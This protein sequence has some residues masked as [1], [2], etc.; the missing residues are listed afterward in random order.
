LRSFDMTGFPLKMTRCF[1]IASAIGTVLSACAVHPQP[2][3]DAERT[4]AANTDRSEL[5]GRD[6][7]VTGPITLEEAMARAIRHNLDQRAKMMEQVLAQK[8]LDL[9]NFDLLPKLTTAAGYT[10]RDQLLASRSVGLASGSTTVPPSYSSEKTDLTYD[11]GFSWNLLDLGVSYY[12]AREQADHVLVLEERRRKVVQLMMQQVR[13]AYWEAAGAQRLRERIEPL[14]EDAHRALA[15]SQQAQ[16]EQ[17]RTPVEALNYQRELLEIMRQLEVVRGHLEEAKPRLAALMNLDPGRDY[18]LAPPDGFAL[19]QFRMPMERMEQLALEGRP[20]LI[21]A[22]YN[23][24]IGVEEAHKALAKLLPGIELQV[25]TNYDNNSFLSYN[26]WQNAGVQVSWNL[27]NLLNVKNIRGAAAAQLTLAHTQRLALSMA[28]LTQVHVASSDL[29]ARR[30]EFELIRKL[31]DVDQQILEHTRNA[32]QATAQGKLEE[33][34][35]AASAM[36]SELRLYEGYGELQNAY[37][38]LLATLGLDPVPAAVESNDL[39]SLEQAI[40]QS[41]RRWAELGQ[42]SAAP[43]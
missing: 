25:G 43:R 8:Q 23:E 41:Q 1:L 27:L 22:N 5:A 6:D 18:Q 15:D 11:I 10:A 13:E 40:T 29:E 34:R 2:F 38:N 16:R 30:Q 20:D 3:S 14:L 4:Q 12:E 31:S 32:E 28:V 17:L 7:P 35:A 9:S 24:R 26:K 42:P 37:G 21:E 33:I 19:P 39:A 36:I